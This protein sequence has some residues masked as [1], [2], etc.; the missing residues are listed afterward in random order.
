MLPAIS[1][2]S[3]SM[4][5][6]KRKLK[7]P[8]WAKTISV[9]RWC[10][11]FVILPWLHYASS[12]LLTYL[13]T[14]LSTT[15]LKFPLLYI[16]WE[17][18]RP[19]FVNSYLCQLFWRPWCRARILRKCKHFAAH[20]VRLG[21]TLR[22]GKRETSPPEFGVRTLM[23]IVPLRF[24]HVFIKI[25]SNRLLALQYSNAIKSLLTLLL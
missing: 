25:S 17:W 9:G 5:A 18:R 20:T 19:N 7:T 11:V 14:Y 8:F 21:R 10:G 3:L 1:D 12:G 16:G 22:G 15:K 23:Q 4:N 6:F 2:R 24:Y 13:L